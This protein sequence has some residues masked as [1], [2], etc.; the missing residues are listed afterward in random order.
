MRDVLIRK[1]NSHAPEAHELATRLVFD[2]S[3]PG[4]MRADVD[5]MLP[6]GSGMSDRLAQEALGATAM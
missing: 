4:N 6:D 1:F 2:S 3:F 5:A